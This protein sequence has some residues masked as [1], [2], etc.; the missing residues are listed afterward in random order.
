MILLVVVLITR[1]ALEAASVRLLVP[2]HLLAQRLNLTNRANGS[3]LAA[4]FVRAW[5]HEMGP[6]MVRPLAGPDRVECPR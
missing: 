1:K 2:G 5:G 4:F 6:G 3:Q